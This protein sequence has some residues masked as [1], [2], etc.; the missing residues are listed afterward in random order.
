MPVWEGIEEDAAVVW[1]SRLQ[2]K[3]TDQWVPLRKSDC[4]SLNNLYNNPKS[5]EKKIY[6]DGGR[7]TADLSNMT[8]TYH[9]YDVPVRDLCCGS[10]FVILKGGNPKS[11]IPLDT[12]DAVRV[13]LMYQKAVKALSTFGDGKQSVLK[14]EIVLC[15]N[16]QNFK[17][18]LSSSG[19]SMSIR[20]RPVS[21][22]GALLFTENLLIQRG[23][24]AYTVDGEVEEMS[25]GP[26]KHVVFV[27]HGI[28]EA[29]WSRTD[30]S[31]PSLIDE[32]DN[33]RAA[34][35]KRMYESWNKSCQKA[36][37]NNEI[38]PLPPNRTEFLPIR[39]FEV[40]H[41]HSSPVKKS[42]KSVTLK[43]IP[44]MRSL[45]NDVV[46]DV[47]MYLTPEFCMETLEFVTKHIND[48]LKKIM[49][50]N[51]D[52]DPLSKEVDNGCWCSII[53]H[54]LGSVI[55]W[56]ILS[57]L[58][59]DMVQRENSKELSTE[60][61][62]SD[63]S[64]D[65]ANDIPLWGPILPSPLKQ[66]L[67]FTPEYILFLGS[68]IGL[69]LSL[70]GA[71]NSFSKYSTLSSDDNDGL[72]SS[73]ALPVSNGLYNI[74]HPSDPVA[75]RIEPLLFPPGFEPDMIPPPCFLTT[76]EGGK[77]LHTRFAQFGLDMQKTFSGPKLNVDKSPDENVDKKQNS[78]SIPSSEFKFALGGFSN[79]RVDYQLQQGL[80]ENDYVSS[81]AAH[82][83]YFRNDDVTS[84]VIGLTCTNTTCNIITTTTSSNA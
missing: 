39:W 71:S 24:G 11:L 16:E 4:I 51:P 15:G 23:Y 64:S 42:V 73:F 69:F 21:W 83:S 8:I 54:S 46:F 31:T 49:D 22:L 53:G 27:V 57:A 2:G 45:A 34:V 18:V 74:F 41:G 3:E 70:R 81:L 61:E 80:V 9:F 10:W 25:L 43:T 1:L 65:S 76:E 35:Y 38:E 37:K 17:A 52:F 60:K 56:D 30:V 48:D 26:L 7:A 84:F 50:I 59:A 72:I 79:T 13:E 19:E 67:V 62:N 44:L 20:R 14:E 78:A 75:Y 47:L 63:V 66:K 36:L 32:I 58:K 6:I 82:T 5:S 68:P 12:D 40:L 33:F 55:V 77:T 28:G 29:M